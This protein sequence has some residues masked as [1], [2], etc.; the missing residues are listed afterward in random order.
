MINRLL[1]TLSFL[2]VMASCGE[3]QGEETGAS[4]IRATNVKVPAMLELTVSESCRLNI[5]GKSNLSK[6]DVII[7]KSVGGAEYSCNI[8]AFEDESYLEF[9]PDGEIATGQYTVYVKHRGKSYYLGATNVT[10]HSNVDIKPAYGSNLYGLVSA[11]GK[12]VS[13]VVVSDGKEVV[14]TD[15]NGVYQMTS[16]KKYQYV[17]VSIPSGYE[18]PSKGILPDFYTETSSDPDAVERVDFTLIPAEND[19]FTLFVLGDMHIANRTSANNDMGQMKDFA[20]DLNAVISSTP[21]KKYIL[22]LGDMTWD[23]YW[24]SRKFCFP[25][26]LNLMNEYFKDIQFFHTMGNHDNDMNA[27]GDFDK[28]FRYTREIAPTF[29]SFNLG[30]YH[31]VV[32]DNIDYNSVVSNEIA[33]KDLRSEQKINFTADQMG[34]LAKDLYHVDRS[35]PVII[36]T[37]ASVFAPTSVTG[38]SAHMNGANE[39][40]EANTSDFLLAVKDYD[41][42]VLTGD[43][44]RMFNYTGITSQKF[45][46]HN[47]GAVCATWWWS[48]RYS[49]GVHISTDG[50]PGGYGIFTFRG[51]T[52]SRTY[53]A[54][55]WT[56]DHQFNVYDM[57]QVKKLIT[58]DYAGGKAVFQKY[59]D[60]M[61]GFSDDDILMNVW[62]VDKDWTIT[63]TEDG[64]PL[65]VTP[66]NTYDPLHIAAYWGKRVKASSS[67]PDFATGKW[68]HFFM[69]TATKPDSNIVITVT[70]RNGKTYQESFRRPKPFTV[71]SFSTNQ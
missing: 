19:N 1:A 22:T 62:D 70:D 53:K 45:E 56:L 38:Y 57:G 64:T 42:H 31:F 46:E 63:V 58:M 3:K 37:H 25:E 69:V 27:S 4:S 10:V 47:M 41:V 39:P 44:H 33:G 2:C 67:T 71:E 30:Q 49:P 24:Y 16:D 65:T 40:G 15:K 48:T 17:F 20:A 32:M 7:F 52:L 66:V 50:S 43:T 55:G 28:A 60:A 68:N 14:V 23:Y 59:V 26:Y 6:D 9:M 12:G 51:K 8:T 13:G 21:G 29:Y 61:N 35:T 5:I 36:S 54:I 11:N 18:V 34:W